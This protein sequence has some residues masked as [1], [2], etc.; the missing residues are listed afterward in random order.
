[1][2]AAARTWPSVPLRLS[3]LLLSFLVATCLYAYDHPLSANAIREAYFLGQR[4]DEKTASFLAQYIKRLPTPERGPHISEIS[5]YTPY[6][7][8]VL[9]SWRKN[10]EY[11]AQQ[12][13]RDFLSHPENI[14]VRVKIEFTPT[15]NAMQ[16]AEPDKEVEGEQALIL[17]R[18]DFWRDFRFRLSQAGR[19]ISRRDIH[20]SPI[21]V[22]GGLAGAEV[23]LD[24]DAA[25]VAPERAEVEVISLDNHRV[26][27]EFDL[28]K[29]Q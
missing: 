19:E 16:G 23:W 5:L 1:M 15:Y 26:A 10:I 21:Y 2:F 18:K 25:G 22:R 28:A 4:S 3:V 24:Y 14:R 29:L 20:G 9:A 7:Q 13:Q 8:V 12:A 11:S 6:A 27:A 17:R